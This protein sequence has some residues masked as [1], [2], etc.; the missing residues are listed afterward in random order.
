MAETLA[1]I[2][3]FC[4]VW[5]TSTRIGTS[6]WNTRAGSPV[7]EAGSRRRTRPPCAA[8]D[9]RSA[10]PPSRSLPS[11][12]APSA[13][14]SALPAAPPL[15]PIGGPLARV[16]APLTCCR[17][18]TWGCLSRRQPPPATSCSPSASARRITPRFAPRTAPVWSP[19]SRYRTVCA[20]WPLPLGFAPGTAPEGG[21]V[22]RPDF[23]PRADSKSA[24]FPAFVPCGPSGLG[25]T[26]EPPSPPPPPTRA[27]WGRQCIR[28]RKRLPASTTRTA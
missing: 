19:T 26:E 20:P 14:R 13:P 28:A 12:P 1:A 9:H 17:G 7:C 4:R 10:L 24:I 21:H 15:Q 25:P 5:T 23:P 8:V 11:P 2:G 18:P 27:V 3:T 6:S 22:P 16:R